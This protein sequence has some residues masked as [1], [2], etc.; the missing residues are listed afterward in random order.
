MMKSKDL[1]P[2][3]KSHAKMP[4]VAAPI[5]PAITVMVGE[6]SSL[7]VLAGASVCLAISS[8][9][10]I[11]YAVMSES[12]SLK[13]GVRMGKPHAKPQAQRSMIANSLT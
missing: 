13:L 10:S 4:K 7:S 3:K 5:T 1:K 11:F 6:S 2:G 12:G 9:I 8:I